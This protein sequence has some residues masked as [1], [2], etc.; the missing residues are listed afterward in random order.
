MAQVFLSFSEIAAEAELPELPGAAESSW[1]LPHWEER[2]M[3]EHRR[4]PGSRQPG[5]GAGSRQGASEGVGNGKPL[6]APFSMNP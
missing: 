6:H 3:A 2:V 5:T 4:K 1:G